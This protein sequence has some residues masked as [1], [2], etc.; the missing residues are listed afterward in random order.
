[1]NLDRKYLKRRGESWYLKLP[2]PRPLR[3]LYPTSSGKPREHIEEALNTRDLHEAN[4]LKHRRIAH[5]YA[6]F[7]AKER[8]AAGHLSADVEEARDF[9]ASLRE[10]RSDDEARDN[11]DSAAERARAIE[12]SAGYDRAKEFFKLATS[13]KDTLREA[14]EKWMAANEHNAA[15]KLKDEQAFRGLM[16]F[17]GVADGV[18]SVVTGE[19]ARAYVQWLNTEAQSARGGPLAKATKEARIAPLRIFWHDYLEHHEIVPAGGV[20]PWRAHKI[21]GKR[22][23][24]EAQP[25]KKR[26]YTDAEILALLN[27]PE[28]RGGKDVRYPKRTIIEMYALCFYTGARIGEI[29]NRTIGDV[30]KIRGGYVLHIRTGKTDESPRS[31]PIYHPIPVEVLKQRIGKR[32]DARAQLFEEFIPGGPNGSLAWYISKAM[33]HYR[34]KVG[35]GTATDTHSTRRRLI[36][37]L[38]AKGHPL[39]LVQFYVGHKPAGITAGVYA[40]PTDEGLRTIARAVRYP[41]AIERALNATLSG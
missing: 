18:P 9:R 29:A 8:G 12:D 20:N 14:W 15:T 19:R 16:D 39:T 17:L 26:P 34:D 32:K 33:G 35:L 23:P 4:R 28:L 25:D 37:D 41:A 27:G 24:G 30:E 40:Q 3:A 22:K 36:T 5:W 38:T 2:I 1:M 6:D 31:I 7:R 21:T 10:A 11:I 13:R